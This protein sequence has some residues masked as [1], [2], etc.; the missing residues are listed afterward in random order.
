MID[1]DGGP[2]VDL[3]MFV[4]GPPE[5]HVRGRGREHEAG[6]HQFV[7]LGAGRQRLLRG[8]RAARG[9][10]QEGAERHR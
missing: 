10:C 4:G 6:V 3:P 2:F 8:R 1:F 9:G 5:E 7:F